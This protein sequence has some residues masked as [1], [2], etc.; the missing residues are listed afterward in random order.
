M[1][2]KS[3]TLRNVRSLDDVYDALVAQLDLPAHFGRNLDAL[4]DSLGADVE[5]PL[6]IVWHD[7]HASRP[8]LGSDVYTALLEILQTVAEERGDMTLDIYH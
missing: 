5:G 1:S 2:M 8:H 4:Y 7:A 3:C 6:E